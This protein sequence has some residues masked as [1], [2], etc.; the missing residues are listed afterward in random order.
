MRARLWYAQALE[1]TGDVRG[2]CGVYAG[3]EADWGHAKPRSITVDSARERM[4]A[5]R[6]GAAPPRPPATR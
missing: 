5:L 2:A 1:Q 6:C 3:I 4:K